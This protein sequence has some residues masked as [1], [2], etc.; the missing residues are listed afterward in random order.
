MHPMPFRELVA[1]PKPKDK[2]PAFAVQSK[3]RNKAPAW[4]DISGLRTHGE[5]NH[6]I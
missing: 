5:S 3:L 2:K 6:S 4:L 1:N